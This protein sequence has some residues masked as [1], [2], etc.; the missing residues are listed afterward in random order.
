M[1]VTAATLALAALAAYWD[2][3]TGEI[4]NWL[5]LPLLIITPIAYLIFVDRESAMASVVGCACC[6]LVPYLL[7]RIGAIGGGDVKLF[8]ALGAINGVTVGLAIFFAVMAVAAVQAVVVLC[9]RKQ[10]R[11][12]LKN[13]SLVVV[14][15]MRPRNGRPS[16]SHE[17]LTH[18]R[19]GP[20][21]FVGGVLG[22]LGV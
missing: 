6:G 14:N 11:Q 7:F 17:D 19:L 21:L 12:T 9:G 13:I 3:R 8:A 5:T 4:P 16:I 22:R 15:S 2:W 18:M 20:A 10:L 1:L